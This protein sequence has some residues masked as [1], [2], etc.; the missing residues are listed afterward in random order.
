[1]TDTYDS[2]LEDFVEDFVDTNH[3]N[4]YTDFN[5]HE[6]IDFHNAIQLELQKEE[7]LKII[8]KLKDLIPKRLKQLHHLKT[9]FQ[10]DTVSNSLLIKYTNDLEHIYN[11]IS[12][13]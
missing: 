1:M 4:D 7:Q 8:K 6:L 3:T 11:G 5:C 2:V 9:A 12:Q 10:I 13:L